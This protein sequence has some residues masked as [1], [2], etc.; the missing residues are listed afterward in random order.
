M[1]Q[2]QFKTVNE[3]FNAENVL[4]FLLVGLGSFLRL[5]KLDNKGL[6]F[7]EI[8]EV[9]VASSNSISDVLLGASHHLAPPLDYLIL[10]MFLHFGNSD[11]IV[12]FPSVIFGILSIPLIYKIGKLL[13]GVEEGLL[14]AFLLSI[15]PMHIWYSQETRMYSLF[16]F[17]S[18]LSLLFFIKAINENTVMTWLGFIISTTLNIYTHYFAFF[19]ILIYVLF[20]IIVVFKNRYF[21]DKGMFSRHI[22]KTTL[23]HFILSILAVIFLYVPQISIFLRQ[24]SGLNGILSYGLPPTL[25]FFEMILY[26]M[27]PWN[28]PGLVVYL[29]FFVYGL[30][31]IFKTEH[32][33][34]I[35]LL[36]LWTIVPIM[37]SFILTYSR[38]PMTT[39]RNLIFILPIFLLLISKGITSIGYLINQRFQSIF[40]YSLNKDVII[41]LL[42]ILISSLSLSNTTIDNLYN[43]QNK[44]D[45]DTGAYLTTHV[46][47]NEL[48]VA[49]GH[50][51]SDIS[52]YYKGDGDIRLIEKNALAVH[53]LLNETSTKNCTRIWFVYSDIDS[54]MYRGFNNDLSIWLDT[55]CELQKEGVPQNR[56]DL[57]NI[58]MEVQKLLNIGIKEDFQSA[59]LYTFDLNNVSIKRQSSN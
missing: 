43:F 20:L 11:F 17:L 13:F 48:I 49:F 36:A 14:G 9:I 22:G 27:G 55:N 26:K 51:V 32:R 12:R 1:M 41:I 47:S 28:I 2:N 42:V 57:P 52:Y 29:G 56:F 38:G 8:G 59:A 58:D 33:D 16:V 23:F 46:K 24:T 15:A 53:A 10:H 35:T 18:L 21:T 30:G 54:G 6:W 45:K 44:G 34:Q 3:N 39:E 5:Y 50:T 25:Y 7:D 31:H 4:L 40:R 19:V 37:F